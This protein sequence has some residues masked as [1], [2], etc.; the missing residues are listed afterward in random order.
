MRSTCPGTRLSFGKVVTNIVQEGPGLVH[1]C[2]ST[3]LGR[4]WLMQSVTTLSPLEQSVIHAV[5]AEP[6]VPVVLGK[7]FL[8]SAMKQF[9]KDIPIWTAK[10]FRD[11]PII[12]KGD[13]K[14]AAFRSWYSQFYSKSSLRLAYTHIADEE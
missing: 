7:L 9:E 1:I 2:Y 14:I 4:I 11:K 13:G 8:N 6:R 10:V 5:W 3:P 12:V